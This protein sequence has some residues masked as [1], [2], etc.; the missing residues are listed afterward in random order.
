MC[1]ICVD[2]AKGVI[3]YKEAYN[4][5]REFIHTGNV[6]DRHADV[7]LEEIRRQREMSEDIED[8]NN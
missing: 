1:I 6:T 7:I 2:M 5:L 4:H 3:N 8:L